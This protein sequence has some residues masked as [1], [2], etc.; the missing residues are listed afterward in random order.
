MGANA[1]CNPGQKAD[2]S[3]CNTVVLFS[4][5]PLPSLSLTSRQAI[6]QV[7]QRERELERVLE[8]RGK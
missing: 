2:S 6:E 7:H 1:S 3:S 5:P 8:V 4:L